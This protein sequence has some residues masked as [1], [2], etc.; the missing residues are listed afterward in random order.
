MRS[1]RQ[2]TKE[3]MINTLQSSERVT[4]LKFHRVLCNHYDEMNFFGKLGT[5]FKGDLFSK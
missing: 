2:K 3:E 5:F 4:K 1:K